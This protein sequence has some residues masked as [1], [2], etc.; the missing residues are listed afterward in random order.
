[1]GEGSVPQTPDLNL[2]RIGF[3]CW[4][5][6]NGRISDQIPLTTKYVTEEWPAVLQRVRKDSPMIAA[7]LRDAS[8]EQVEGE[9]IAIRVRYR[10][11][12]TKL[13]AHGTNATALVMKAMGQPV[14]LTLLPPH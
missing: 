5:I 6:D 3:A 9:N 13:L 1:M 4:L 7:L 10:L 11:H 12:H 2:S 8:V 14:T